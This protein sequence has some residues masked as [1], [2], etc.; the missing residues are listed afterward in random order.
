[1]LSRANF[2]YQILNKPSQPPSNKIC[3][4]PIGSAVLRGKIQSA[5]ACTI[6]C[7]LQ[8]CFKVLYA[9]KHSTTSYTKQQQPHK[10]NIHMAQKIGLQKKELLIFPR[11]NSEN[12]NRTST[13]NIGALCVIMWPLHRKHIKLNS[14]G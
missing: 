5:N 1:M 6:I 12:A 13:G 11:K 7:L 3:I 9:T 4:N 14:G 2:L 8:Q 10:Q